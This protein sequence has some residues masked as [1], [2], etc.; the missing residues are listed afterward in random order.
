MYNIH[1]VEAFFSSVNVPNDFGE[2]LVI[3]LK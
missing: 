1:K 3:L 2:R